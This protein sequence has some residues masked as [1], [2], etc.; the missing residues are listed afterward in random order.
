[1]DKQTEIIKHR[2]NRIA[3]FYD[4]FEAMMEKSQVQKWRGL[5]W[6]QVRGKVLEVGV[7]TGKNIPYYPENT[8]VTAIDFSEKMLEKARGKAA[9]YRKTADLMLM[10]AQQLE[11]PDETF[12]TV[13]TTFVFCSVP[14]PVKGLREIKRVLKKDGRIIMMEHVRSKKA[15]LG[16]VMD[17]INPLTVRIS[18][19]N[20]N[21]RTLENLKDAGLTVELEQNLMLD[22][23]KHLE[24]GRS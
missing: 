12:D 24:C 6:G 5:I 20:M 15:L 11:F 4:Q 13:I 2:Y 7:G 23:V 14:D 19:A 16:L 18:G 3:G 1:M 22:I 8:Q 10:D 21:R 17:L 9:L